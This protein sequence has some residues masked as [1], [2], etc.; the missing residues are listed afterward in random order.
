MRPLRR[1]TVDP[2]RAAVSILKVIDRAISRT[3]RSPLRTL[4]EAGQPQF[5]TLV[6]GV[7]VRVPNTHCS[8]PLCDFFGYDL[9]AASEGSEQPR[10]V[11]VHIGAFAKPAHTTIWD[12][13]GDFGFE[14]HAKGI[15]FEFAVLLEQAGAVVQNV[16]VVGIRIPQKPFSR[17]PEV[18][19]HC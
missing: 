16:H 3:S 4:L 12:I 7:R 14:M 15:E 13:L 8:W 19:P 17:F 6:H 10:M 2:P 11:G 1:S 9:T 5:M 18:L